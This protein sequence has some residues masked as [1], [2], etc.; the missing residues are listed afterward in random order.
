MK[1]KRSVLL[2]VLILLPFVVSANQGTEL[3]AKFESNGQT[4]VFSF[5]VS[6]E[7][8]N[9]QIQVGD[10]MLKKDQDYSISGK[11]LTLK[12]KV[13]G[14]TL[15][16]VFRAKQFSGSDFEG[17]ASDAGYSPSSSAGG[18]SSAS[19]GGGTGS[20][21][22]PQATGQPSYQPPESLDSAASQLKQLYYNRDQDY[23]QEQAGLT[24]QIEMIQMQSKV[25][26]LEVD[27]QL[28]VVEKL[29][30]QI[31]AQA[32]SISSKVEDGYTGPDKVYDA[33]GALVY[34]SA[35]PEDQRWIGAQEQVMGNENYKIHDENGRLIYDSSLPEGERFQG[36]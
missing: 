2:A 12:N 13:V 26:Q 30:K 4:R 19:S 15:I 35:L 1:F 17:S 34:D 10:K 21:S 7:K 25:N 9:L 33:K 28:Q 11:L 18:G 6:L 3:L 24:A 29:S 20:G 27:R 36:K 31:S 5:D 8:M 22:G 16:R 14:G 23:H 32:R